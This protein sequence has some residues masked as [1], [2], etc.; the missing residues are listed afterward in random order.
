MNIN[1]LQNIV[2]KIGYTILFKEIYLSNSKLKYP[3]R[4]NPKHGMDHNDVGAM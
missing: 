1:I 2:Q 4:L 3:S